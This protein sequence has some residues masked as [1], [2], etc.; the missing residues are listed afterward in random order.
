[1]KEIVPR[2]ELKDLQKRIEDFLKSYGLSKG[3][4]EIK[5]NHESNRFTI[6]TE[7][8]N[9]KGLY[10]TLYNDVFTIYL[11]DGTKTLDSGIDVE[12][13]EAI[14]FKT[15]DF[16]PYQYIIY[17]YPQIQTTYLADDSKHKKGTISYQNCCPHGCGNC[18]M[19]LD[20]PVISP[21]SIGWS[22]FLEA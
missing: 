15:A 8:H 20:E 3:F 4:V 16:S 13:T 17:Q 5:E 11:I 18:E 12:Y 6:S 1:M 22:K 14:V 2:M 19:E 10:P 7:S 21:E 9:L